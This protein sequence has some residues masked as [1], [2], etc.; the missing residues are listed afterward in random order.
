MPV[1]RSPW[2]SNRLFLAE[3]NVG[4]RI[5][6]CDVDRPEHFRP[7]APMEGV[8]RTAPTPPSSHRPFEGRK[9]GSVEYLDGSRLELVAESVVIG[10]DLAIN[11]T[12]GVNE[13][14][15]PGVSAGTSID[16]LTAPLSIQSSASQPLYLM[17]GLVK[18]DKGFIV[19]PYRITIVVAERFAHNGC[20]YS[21]HAFR[22]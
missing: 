3:G 6:P 16:T 5:A 14:Y 13:S 8:G 9:S 19:I 20:A 12:P 11:F 22:A 21:A 17:A 7:S 18:I 1:A 2:T 4:L 10:N 15:T